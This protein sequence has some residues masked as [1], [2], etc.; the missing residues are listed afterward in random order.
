MA[1]RQSVADM[2]CTLLSIVR[3]RLELFALEA[4]DQKAHLIAALGM[5]FGALLFLT[6]AVLVFSIAV[7]LYFWPT[8]ARYMALGILAL[9]YLVLGVGLLW[10]VR[11]KLLFEPMP[12]AATIDE[13][14]RDLALVER[15]REHPTADEPVRPQRDYP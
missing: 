9:V 13:L 10:G 3:T 12:F 15:L 1:L 6:L 14:R 2:A 4:S 5:A 8:D 11:R 7:A